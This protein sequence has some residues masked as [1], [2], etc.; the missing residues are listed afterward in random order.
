MLINSDKLCET[1]CHATV[2]MITKQ[3]ES[4]HIVTYINP[5]VPE[6]VY[7]LPSKQVSHFGGL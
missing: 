6:L 2:G 4:D 5:L 3:Q 1:I 7:A